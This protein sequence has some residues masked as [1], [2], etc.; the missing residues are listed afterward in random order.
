MAGEYNGLGP[1][2]PMALAG[3]SQLQP[4]LNE[5]NFSSENHCLRCSKPNSPHTE[6]SERWRLAADL[7]GVVALSIIASVI[8][9]Q[10]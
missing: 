8:I 6:Q 10:C 1:P 3:K 9:A 7:H 5:T 4:V 2:A